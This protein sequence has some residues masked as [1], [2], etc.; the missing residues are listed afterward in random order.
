MLNHG[1]EPNVDR[2]QKN[3]LSIQTGLRRRATEC[4]C[5]G[6]PI[7][8]TEYLVGY[9]KNFRRHVLYH[10]P[11]NPAMALFLKVFNGTREELAGHLMTV[12]VTR[13]D[14]LMTDL[15]EKGKRV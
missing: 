10:L 15:R 1:E 5:L 7:I 14:F 9:T 12:I 13:K 3:R 11:I 6:H 8:I 2:R 4:D